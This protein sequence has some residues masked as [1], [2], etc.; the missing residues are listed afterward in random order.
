MTTSFSLGAQRA[1]VQSR[2]DRAIEDVTQVVL[3]QSAAFLRW[4]HAILLAER[5][6]RG[7]QQGFTLRRMHEP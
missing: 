3:S 7:M 5:A 1:H 6:D 2:A 4:Q